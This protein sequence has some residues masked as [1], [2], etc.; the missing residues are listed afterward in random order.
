MKTSEIKDYAGAALR[1]LRAI[2]DVLVSPG[3]YT[4]FS[5]DGIISPAVIGLSKDEMRSLI[6]CN[7]PTAGTFSGTFY[8]TCKKLFL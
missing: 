4:Y 8:K 3:D 6:M 5:S 2:P 1:Q 7:I